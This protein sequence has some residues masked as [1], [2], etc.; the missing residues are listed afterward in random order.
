MYTYSA[1]IMRVVDGDTVRLK[2]DLGF[3]IITFINVRVVTKDG[4]YFDTPETRLGKNTDE[5]QK[6]L[7]LKAKVRAQELL[8]QWV[9]VTIKT[10]KDSKGKFGRYLAAIEM[11]DG[12]DFAEVM[13]EEGLGHGR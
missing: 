2:I 7:G 13:I 5:E 6:K 9:D 12:R 8:P 1:S 11:E 4:K 3:E 10:W